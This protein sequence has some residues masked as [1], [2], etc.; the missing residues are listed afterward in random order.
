MNRKNTADNR[1]LSFLLNMIEKNEFTKGIKKYR[2]DVF[3]LLY[4]VFSLKKYDNDF[5]LKYIS[6]E[7]NEEFKKIMYITFFIGR[8]TN[9]GF[10]G[11]LHWILDENKF[12]NLT[13]FNITEISSQELFINKILVN[14][15]ED[16]EKEAK[17]SQKNYQ[18]FLKISNEELIN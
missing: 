12:Y 8:S 3:K 16:L 9:I 17:S 14:K 7:E 11:A 5:L 10:Y 4:K 15:M 18:Q 1:F 2:D 6:K 13:K